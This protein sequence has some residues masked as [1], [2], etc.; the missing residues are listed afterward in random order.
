MAL[1][2]V[3]ERRAK[4]IHAAAE[5][6]CSA[7]LLVDT[8]EVVLEATLGEKLQLTLADRDAWVRPWTV[9]KAADPVEWDSAVDGTWH[10]RRLRLSESASGRDDARE[11]DLVLAGDVIRIE[12]PPVNTPDYKADTRSWRVESVGAVGRVSTT[13]LIQLQT[14]DDEQA[15]A[16]PEGDDTWRQYQHRGETA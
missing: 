11:M 3:G 12:D 6:E 14:D 13:S 5:D 1:D 7:D 8:R 10:T 4:R 9:I 16:K 15:D 2:G